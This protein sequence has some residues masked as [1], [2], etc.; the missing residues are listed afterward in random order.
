MGSVQSQI[1]P[2]SSLYFFP[3]SYRPS[4]VVGANYR[5]LIC[6]TCHFQSG[7][8]F[9]VYF[10][11][12]CLQVS[13]VCVSALTQGEKVGTYLGSLV[14]LCCGEGGMLQTNITGV[15][16]ECLQ[17][18]GHTGFAPA[19]SMCAF[20]VYTA[21]TPGCSAGELSKVSPG[22][23]ALLRSKP[24]RVWGTPQSHRLNWT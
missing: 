11:F 5:I 13:S 8:L 9:F 1:V 18:L 24:F 4:N 23:C 12:F 6:Y 7:S 21:Q 14:Q 3:R 17:C 22:L 10:G 15:C 2:C 16:G 19:H 20:L